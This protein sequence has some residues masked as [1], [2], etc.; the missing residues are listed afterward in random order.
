MC[1]Q[2]VIILDFGGRYRDLIARR[3]REFSVYSEILPGN[4]PIDTIKKIDPLAI[5]LSGSSKNVN[6]KGSILP[7]K[8]IYNL[9]VPVLGIGYG[10]QLIALQLGGSV[11]PTAADIDGIYDISLDPTSRIFKGLE[12]N[13]TVLM[14]HS[15]QVEKLPFGFRTVASTPDMPNAAFEKTGTKI[16]GV[17]F[18]LESS[19]TVAGKRI[20]ERFLFSVCKADGNFTL[21]AYLKDQ[22]KRIK[23]Q[24]GKDK[25]VLGLS[26]GVDSAVVAAILSAAV[27]NQLT[28]IFVDHG[29]MRKDEGDEI[30][31]AFRGKSLKLIRVDATRR[32]MNKLKGV[33]D[34]EKKRKIIGEQFIK[35]FNKQA[36]RLGNVKYLAQ[37]TIYPDVIESG[38]SKTTLIK[39]HHNVG[40]LPKDLPFKELVEPLKFLFKDEVRTLGK[41]LGL[42]ASIVNRQPF[43]GP[44]LAIRIIGDITREKADILREAD[45]IFREEVDNANIAADQYFAVLTNTRSVGIDDVSRS[46]EYTI[47]L[48]AVSS[49]DF[50]KAEYVPIPH[51][52]LSKI[53]R[54]LTGEIKG[55]NRVVYDITDKPPAT[56]EWE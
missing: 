46:Y 37:G 39:S 53:S 5:I 16:F 51:D 47:A 45:A 12:E 22:V 19:R 55:V 1:K 30:E 8:E 54:R 4:T 14:S 40:G 31:K 27:P 10:A 3:V 44:G 20:L 42:P 13:Q 25:I 18:F 49:S 11:K 24:V 41:I 56:I 17:Q 33:T 38:L 34:P 2:T 6:D 52:V 50:M 15:A 43:P 48:R 36:Q 26:G 28:C 9:G 32:F 23:K 7:D 21:D 29:L 35:V